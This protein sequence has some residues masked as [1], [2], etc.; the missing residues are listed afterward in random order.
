MNCPR[1]AERI[2]PV[3]PAWWVSP[4]ARRAGG[5]QLDP[6]REDEH[7]FP[8]T[9]I[10]RL[11]AL[12]ALPAWVPPALPAAGVRRLRP[13]GDRALRGSEHGDDDG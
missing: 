5:H 12:S 4:F 3:P 10:L 2:P 8:L 9:V 6:V 7:G 11:P 13:R 1:P